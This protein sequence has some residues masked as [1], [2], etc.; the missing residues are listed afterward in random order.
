[1]FI[2][3]AGDTPFHTAIV[4]KTELS[5]KGQGVGYEESLPRRMSP[6]FLRHCRFLRSSGRSGRSLDITA[7]R[8][9]PRGAR[10]VRLKDASSSSCRGK[11][12]GMS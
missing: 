9:H 2:D 3:V 6:A 4:Y 8:E 5:S 7:S 12:L 10:R 11:V 1:M